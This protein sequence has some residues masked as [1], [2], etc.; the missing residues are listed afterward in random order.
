MA[1]EGKVAWC[2]EDE[3]LYAIPD[4]VEDKRVN[5]DFC[6]TVL[7]IDDSP[8]DPDDLS[9]H[10]EL[11]PEAEDTYPVT[12]SERGNWPGDGQESAGV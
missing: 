9:G 12:E 6:R 10:F 1:Y 4:D 5:P 11:V 2:I 3:R 7:W 8:D